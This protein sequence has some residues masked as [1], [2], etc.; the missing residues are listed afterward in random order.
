M[1]GSKITTFDLTATNGMVHVIDTV[2]MPP[3][4]NIVDLVVGNSD[5]STLLSKVQSAGLA[6]ALQGTLHD[7]LMKSYII[8]KYCLQYQDISN[9][10]FIG[11]ALTVFAPTN[12]AFNRLGSHVLDNLRRD[13]QLLKGMMIS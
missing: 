8:I 3:T 13:P 6:G 9:I 4:G 2:M 7:Y 11:D 12:A 10:Y 5:L 1:E